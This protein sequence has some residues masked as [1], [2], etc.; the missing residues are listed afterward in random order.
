MVVAKFNAYFMPAVNHTHERAIFN[1]RVQ[2]E[3]ESTEMFIRSLFEL[4]KMC[5]FPDKEAIRDVGIQNRALAERLQRMADLT[6]DAASRYARMNWSNHRLISSMLLHMTEWSQSAQM[7]LKP[8]GR[9]S[10]RLSW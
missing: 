1:R 8:V 6:L 7:A 10:T 9:W 3:G 2:Q 4:S 5:N